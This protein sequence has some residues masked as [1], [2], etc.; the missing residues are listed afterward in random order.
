M[1]VPLG[2]KY[3]EDHLIFRP[4]HVLS[5]AAPADVS[6]HRRIDAGY[7]WEPTPTA[8]GRSAPK[9][10]LG[11]STAVAVPVSAGCAAIPGGVIC[12]GA[13]RRDQLSELL[14]EHRMGRCPSQPTAP[15]QGLTVNGYSIRLV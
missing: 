2:A 10:R 8:T 12:A 1:R 11:R 9:S 14:A 15:R 7:V 6:R 5:W 13:G 4:V 3:A